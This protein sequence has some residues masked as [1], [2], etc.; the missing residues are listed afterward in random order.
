[1][2]YR[3]W[4]KNGSTEIKYLEENEGGF[5]KTFNEGN[6]LAIE[7]AWDECG[8]GYSSIISILGLQDKVIKNVR[9]EYE[10]GSVVHE[11]LSINQALVKNLVDVDLKIKDIKFPIECYN[12]V[13]NSLVQEVDNRYDNIE[14]KFREDKREKSAIAAELMTAED[15]DR[16]LK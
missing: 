14:S 10:N 12:G 11:D 4:Y 13:Y 2:H 8:N 7:E 15:L 3:I 9:V 1:M 16:I 5:E 6:V